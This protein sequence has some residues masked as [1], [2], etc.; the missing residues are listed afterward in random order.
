MTEQKHA[1]NKTVKENWA[2]QNLLQNRL[3][4]LG[5][6][7]PI[8][9]KTSPDAINEILKKKYNNVW[10]KYNPRD[11]GI[12]RYGI[13]I[14]SHDGNIIDPI[15][16]DSIRQYNKENGTHYTEQSFSIHTPIVNDIPYIKPVL[17]M[18]NGHVCRS[19]YL[20]LSNG[21]YFPPHRDGVYNTSFRILIPLTYDRYNTFFMFEEEPK[22]FENGQAYVLNT[23][24]RHTVISLKDHM[25][26]IVLNISLNNET[27]NTVYNNLD[28]V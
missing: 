9:F 2:E 22:F 24:K 8:K 16:L 10:Q 20:R 25:D 23:V 27:V 6:I 4:S 26:M 7:I 19:H 15:S 17:D 28:G 13:P 11:G 3:F 14:T 18:F 12:A 1:I 21:G 5:D